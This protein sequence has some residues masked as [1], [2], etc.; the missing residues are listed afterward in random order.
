MRSAVLD[1]NV[2]VSAALA[3]EANRS[4]AP[5]ALVEEELFSGQAFI[6]MTSAPLLYE[7]HDVLNR[8]HHGLSARSIH[9]FVDQ[10][11][12]NSTIVRTYNITMG[13]RDRKD[14]KVVETALNANTDVI[15]SGDR[16]LYEPRA[17]YAIAKTGAGIRRRAIRVIGVRAFLAELRSGPRFS[18]LLPAALP[19]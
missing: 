7:L 8:R 17:M 15:V 13:G 1:T 12:L 19:A 10:F 4:S 14:D 18:P 2:I 11:T 6:S 9:S 3:I 16:D 5:R